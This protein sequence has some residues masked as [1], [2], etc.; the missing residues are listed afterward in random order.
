MDLC[1]A[2]RTLNTLRLRLHAG[3]ETTGVAVA[4][5]LARNQDHLRPWDPPAPEGYLSAALQSDRV[6]DGLAAF[7]AGTAFRYWLSLHDAPDEVVGSIHFSQVS[8]GAFHNAVLGYSLDAACQGQG[9]MHEALQAGIAEMFSLR[10]NLHRLQAAWRP[11]NTR[12]GAVL[13]RLGFRDEGLARD[14]LFIN[15]AWRDHR[16]SALTNP[17]FRPPSGW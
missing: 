4:R 15:G 16:I 11:E 9:L 17:A 1:P 13:A 14:Y 3:D 8:R 6:R 10:V 7:A 5:F 12:S 2:Q